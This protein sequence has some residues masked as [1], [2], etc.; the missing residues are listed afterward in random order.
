MAFTGIVCF[1]FDGSRARLDIVS[2]NQE[3]LC[4]VLQAM[5]VRESCCNE[6]VCKKTC[7]IYYR[8]CDYQCDN[9]EHC[10]DGI[11][12][13]WCAFFS[14][15]PTP[16][17]E[18]SQNQVIVLI[19]FFTI[20][21]AS[22]IGCICCCCCCSCCPYYRHRSA[23][24]RQIEP[25]SSTPRQAFVILSVRSTAISSFTV[26]R[27]QSASTLALPEVP[28]AT[29]PISSRALEPSKDEVPAQNMVALGSA[30]CLKDDN[31]AC[32]SVKV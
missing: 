30:T 27:S 20:L 21:S 19:T 16:T 10:F 14:P 2:S 6:G 3:E 7:S 11:C 8:S 5:T 4:L 12:S 23:S 32:N 18:L 26:Q 17:T 13:S 25:Q 1:L 24:R 28:E 22:V 9:G 31:L 15:S 29:N